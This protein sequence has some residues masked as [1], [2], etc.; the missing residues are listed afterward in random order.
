MEIDMLYEI[1]EAKHRRIKELENDNTNRDAQ[2]V[3]SGSGDVKYL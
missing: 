1:V 3:Q 2:A